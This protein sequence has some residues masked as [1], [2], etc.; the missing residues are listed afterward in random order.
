MLAW[1]V[2]TDRAACGA[3]LDAVTKE[4]CGG[5]AAGLS[6]LGAKARFRPP[7][8]IEIGGRKVSGSSGYAVGRSAVLQGTILLADEV[9]DMA[10]TLRLSESALRQHTTCLEIEIGA[11]PSMALVIEVIAQ[12]LAEVL[13]R[14]PV[15]GHLH[16]NELALCETLLRDEIGANSYVL[17]HTAVPA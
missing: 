14:K 6:R 13:G 17:R 2:V 9:R 11:P 15:T 1:D 12:G 3:G 4:V 8:D 5:V 7:N 16:Q 10:S